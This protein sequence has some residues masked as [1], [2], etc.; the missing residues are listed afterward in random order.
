M[1][2]LFASSFL[3]ALNKLNSQEKSATKITV[4][5]LQQDPSARGLRFHRIESSK[6]PHFWS[7]RVNQD[8]RVIVHKTENSFLICYVNHHDVAY[9][10]AER[11]RIE[12]H[13]KTGVAQ[14]V[15]V[16]EKIEEIESPYFTKMDSLEYGVA[17]SSRP[18]IPS[19]SIFQVV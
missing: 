18:G 11:R 7:I 19:Q 4:F 5:D 15:E 9:K 2:F 12:T 17:D 3:K 13:P 10:W 14:I 1:Q 16:R 6:D 8:I